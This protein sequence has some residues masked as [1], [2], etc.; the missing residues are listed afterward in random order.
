[1]AKTTEQAA[2]DGTTLAA[3]LAQLMRSDRLARRT[4]DGKTMTWKQYADFLEQ[5]TSTVYK[6][7]MGKHPNPHE[8]TVR[9]IMD[10]LAANPLPKPSS[11]PRAGHDA[12]T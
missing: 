2:P 12:T 8:R 11:Q 6:I 5:P 9:A 3:T 7:A 1:M 10:K 4:P